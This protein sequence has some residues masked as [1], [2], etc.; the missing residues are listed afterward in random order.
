MVV[1]RLTGVLLQMD[2][3]NPNRPALAFFKIDGQLPF[4]HDRVVELA[5]LIALGQ[6]GVEVVLAVKHAVEVYGCLD[7]QA[8]SDR[9]A[10]AHFV[11][12]RQHARQSRVDE[13]NIVVGRFAK[14][15]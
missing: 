2:A 1:D 11:Q 7:A 3:L 5:D 12:N 13:R 15:G 4:A 10:H 9:L 8:G 6:I 14:G